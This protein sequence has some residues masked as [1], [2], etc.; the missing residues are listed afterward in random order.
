M[1]LSVVLIF[2]LL[3]GGVCAVDSDNVSIKEDSNLDDS[4]SVLSSQNKL[5][6]SNE[7][8]ISETNIVNSQND[9]LENASSVSAI[10]SE[11]DNGDLQASNSEVDD[12]NTAILKSSNNEILTAKNTDKVP[13]DISVISATSNNANSIFK[14]KLTDSETGD[15]LVGRTV[16]L[17]LD[18]NNLAGKTDENGIAQITAG[19]LVKGTYSVTLKFSG[20]ISRYAATT[21]YQNVFVDG[22][23]PA[24]ITVVSAISNNVN[25]IFNVRLTDSENGKAI[26]GRTVNLIFD[27]KNLAGKTDENGIAKITAKP[28]VKGTYTVTLKFAGTISHYAPTTV[29]QKVTV[30]GF[31]PAKITVASA[32]SNN[33]K[34]VF[35]VK[36]TDSEM[37]MFWLVVLLI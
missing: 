35:K 18:G 25:S 15:V 29:T 1:L 5:E 8:S 16:N 26:S 7:V 20:T 17:F 32:V 31:V 13:A 10:N 36:L 22:F 12:I 27:G 33:A 34:T 30:N 37:V 3:I 2:F 9:N 21:V 14:V 19:S 28:L 6:I 11:E 24:N 23:V 4:V